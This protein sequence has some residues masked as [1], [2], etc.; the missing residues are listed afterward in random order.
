MKTNNYI[1]IAYMVLCSLISL[2]SCTDEEMVGRRGQTDYNSVAL[3]VSMPTPVV[4]E[5]MTKTGAADFDQMSD[6]NVV[7][8]PKEEG[9]NAEIKKVI[10][11]K[12][13]Q[14]TNSVIAETDNG[15]YYTDEMK[16]AASNVTS[17]NLHFTSEWLEK[18]GI[19]ISNGDVD[20]QFFLVGNWGKSIEQ[21]SNVKTVGDLKDLKA[22][23]ISSASGLVQAPNIM[24]GEILPDTETETGTSH[25]EDNNKTGSCLIYKMN[26]VRTAAMITIMIDGSNLDKDI[27][28]T[29]K[30]VSLHNVPTSCTIGKHNRVHKEGELKPYEG[31]IVANGESKDFFNNGTKVSLA[32]SNTTNPGNYTLVLTAGTH[33]ETD[34]AGKITNPSNQAVAPLFLYENYHG[35][36]FGASGVTTDNQWMKRPAEI[37]EGITNLENVPASCSYI[38]VTADYFK[39]NNSGETPIEKYGTATW[40]F[41]LGGNVTDDFDVLRNHYYKIT[42]SLS[43]SG[44][45]EK[46]YSWRVDADLNQPIVVDDT[47][48][49]LGGGGEMF[50][51]RVNKKNF[52]LDNGTG[53]PFVYIRCSKGSEIEWKPLSEINNITGSFHVDQTGGKEYVWFYVQPMI[54]DVTWTE[55]KDS[56]KR[57]CSIDFCETNGTKV[58]TVTFTQYEPIKIELGYEDVQDPEDEDMQQVKK[59]IETYYNYTFQEGDPTPNGKF[60]MYLDRIDRNSMEWGFSETLL[61]KNH[62]TGFENVYHLIDPKEKGANCD[63]H[64]T[65]AKKYLPTGRNYNEDYT[66]GSCMMHAAMENYFMRYS[67]QPN[68]LTTVGDILN[69]QLPNRPQ[70]DTGVNENLRFCWCVPSIVGWQLIEK[71]DRHYREHKGI[72]SGIFDPAHPIVPW[73]SYW[74]SNAGTADMNDTYSDP[75]IDGK[76]YAFVYQFGRGLDAITSA[77]KY[78]SKYLVRRDTKLHYRLLNISPIYMKEVEN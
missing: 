30:T 17:F 8:A 20:A 76:T 65:E 52:K 32:N 54:R 4:C 67:P 37:S 71:I 40:R 60:T 44:V 9:D 70:E 7:I 25:P 23:A 34:D 19:T 57:S 13:A 22:H 46:E 43:G 42:L 49:V 47:N 55:D 18:N 27:I 48:M 36:G 26:L 66:K 64:V 73:Y 12:Y 58:Q 56:H 29:P 2:S 14:Q 35:E 11:F 41:F 15:V 77:G 75:T 45:N 3:R 72:P 5:P 21:E 61:D 50:R 69:T 78:D 1:Y 53:S 62:S 24:F 16:D 38:E 59:I 63:A 74:T 31:M 28:I 10:Y 51:V 6:L 39:I 68:A 33:Y